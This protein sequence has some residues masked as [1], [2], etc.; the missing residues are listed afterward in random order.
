MMTVT[1][2]DKKDICSIIAHHFGVK[3]EDVMIDCYMDTIGYGTN[4]HEAPSV[5]AVVT[6]YS[7]WVKEESKPRS[8]REESLMN[9][10]IYL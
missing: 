6:T 4:E 8:E 3:I 1:H 2:L 9:G 5:R 10:W 7:D